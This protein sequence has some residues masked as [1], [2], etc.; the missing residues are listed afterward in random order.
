M[1]QPYI[2]IVHLTPPIASE[3]PKV[4]PLI[5]DPFAYLV[6]HPEGKAKQLLDQVRDLPIKPPRA[7]GMFSKLHRIPRDCQWLA[8]E[9]ESIQAQLIDAVANRHGEVSVYHSAVIESVLSHHK[10]QRLAAW[11]LVRP[12]HKR[13]T[14]DS[15][16][17]AT[18]VTS[19]IPLVE[20]IALVKQEAAA[21][22]ARAKAIKELGLIGD[23]G[24][25]AP[26]W[27]KIFAQGVKAG[28]ALE[29][30]PISEAR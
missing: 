25:D 13:R 5:A 4:A 10:Q 12:M 21:S 26:D 8:D 24:D 20:R 7:N 17:D 28:S 14:R 19:A 27:A 29:S 1:V 11:W 3:A 23:K 9:M 30:Q 15:D 6:E 2:P 22:E 16:P 18:N